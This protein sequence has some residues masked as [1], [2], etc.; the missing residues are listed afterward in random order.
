[1]N[2]ADFVFGGFFVHPRHPRS[3]RDPRNS[4]GPN[5]SD[6]DVDENVEPDINCNY[7]NVPDLQSLE[8]SSKDLSVLH[9]NIRSLSLHFDELS[10]LLGNIG[11][12][13][14]LIG[15]SEIKDSVDAPISTNIDIPGYKLHHTHS[16][17]A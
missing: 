3:P 15:L 2:S 13:F 1:M 11:I 5:L 10:A 6:Y 8:T 12:D 4:P 9:M 17:S 14:Q 16:Q 7:Y